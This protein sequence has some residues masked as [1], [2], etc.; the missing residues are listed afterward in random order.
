MF[1]LG[2]VAGYLFRPMAEA[3]I[4]ALIGSF[5]L[6]RTLVPTLA[7]CAVE[8]PHLDHGAAGPA[9]SSRNPL[10]ASSS[11]SSIILGVPVTATTDFSRAFRASEVVC[12]WIFGLLFKLVVVGVI[13]R[14]ELLSVG[15]CRTNSDPR[16]FPDR[17]GDRETARLCDE[18]E[19]EEN[20][21]DD[22]AGSACKRSD[23]Y[24]IAHSAASTSPT[25]TRVRSVHRMRIFSFHSTRTIRRRQL[26][27]SSCGRC[28]RRHS[29]AQLSH[30]CRPTS[31]RR[32]SISACRHQSICK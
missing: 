14:A 1:Q 12:R 27:S 16:A 4:F 2:G 5:L 26:T 13:S 6:S 17:N 29:P 30:F 22:S 21:P 9:A 19:Q 32:F 20:S 31:L 3:V 18:I 10:S 8:L 7:G 23:Q 11:V 15:R 28:C 24:R 25:T